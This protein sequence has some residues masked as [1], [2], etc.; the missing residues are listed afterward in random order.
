MICEELILAYM[1]SYIFRRYFYKWSISSSTKVLPCHSFNQQIQKDKYW[2]NHNWLKATFILDWSQLFA[3][4]I[5]NFTS[6]FDEHS[7]LCNNDII[8]IICFL[9]SKLASS[10][11]V[12]NIPCFDEAL[13]AQFIKLMHNHLR[14][15]N[16]WFCSN[17][18]KSVTNSIQIMNIKWMTIYI[19]NITW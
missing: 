16:W 15:C 19:T 1:S 14:R 5:M 13:Q 4:I 3:S 12:L 11:T 10:S 6:F 2:L 8:Y 18:D 7:F 9:H 17:F